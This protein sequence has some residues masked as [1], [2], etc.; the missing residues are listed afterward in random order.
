[1]T[2]RL[3]LKGRL[4]IGGTWL[5]AQP[6]L[7][8]RSPWDGSLTGT[9][10]TASEKL[11]DDAIRAATDG[12]ADMRRLPRGERS[13][14]LRTVADS[15]EARRD[16]FAELITREMGKPIRL[17]HAE[18]ERAVTTFRLCACEALRLGGEVVPLDITR[19]TEGCAGWT[20]KIPIGPVAAIT[21]FNFPLNLVAHKVGPALAAGNSVIV[22]P[23]PHAPLTAVL[24]GE[25][26][27]QAG[28]PPGAVNVVHAEVPLAERLV[29]D[30][31]MKALSFTG[32]DR[33]GWRLRDLAG[34]K[35][36]ILELGG[37]APAI[38]HEDADLAW[39]VSRLVKS[40]FAA[41]GQVCIKT[42]RL[43][44]HQSLYREF[45]V[46]FVEAM[47]E[48]KV[49]DPM[50]PETIVGPM[51]SESA[52]QRVEEWIAEARHAGAKLITGGRRRG[53]M[54]E[55]TL[56]GDVSPDMKV[57]RE[58]IFGP[59]AV[60]EPYESFDEAL[61]RAN[62]TRYGL[63]AA[64]F[65]RDIGRIAHA[66]RELEFGGVVIND[67][68]SLR[69]DNQPYGGVKSSGLGRE[70]VRWAAEALTEQRMVSVRLEPPPD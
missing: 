4:L 65:T 48:L 66:A 67:S 39:A 18:V 27:E 19:A 5:D 13:R 2:L 3:P 56:L 28:A 69:A 22:K 8:V 25:L 70:G 15:L 59:V 43:I 63:Q 40:A 32:S 11:L 42:Q 52:A 46:W 41:A 34:R 31:R 45:Q 53:T 38:V 10:A 23:A 57:Y 26:I 55:P 50:D 7:E 35:K 33:T 37:N 61:C 9:M 16:E 54:M 58:E 29:L 64:V 30:P 44:V 62:D 24:L 6:H 60:I 68:P 49:G 51:I 14:I 20:L 17:S 47:G 36:V 21:P 12:F 1:M